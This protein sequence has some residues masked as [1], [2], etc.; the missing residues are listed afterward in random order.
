MTPDASGVISC[1][2]AEQIALEGQ[3]PQLPERPAD[4]ANCSASMYFQARGLEQRPV[5]IG[6]YILPPPFPVILVC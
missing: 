5:H 1:A 6:E 3:R 4:L 2:F